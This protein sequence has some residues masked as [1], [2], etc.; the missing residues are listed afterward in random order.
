MCV[1]DVGDVLLRCYVVVDLIFVEIGFGGV[2]GCY[3]GGG[4][5][6]VVVGVVV[7]DCCGLF[8]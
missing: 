1:V 8:G 3:V 6:V 7:V 2:E 5:F 4:E